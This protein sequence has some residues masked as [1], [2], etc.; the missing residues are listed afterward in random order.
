MVVSHGFLKQQAEVPLSEIELA[1]R[2]KEAFEE[3]P[4]AHSFEP[5]A[6]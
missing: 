3:D 2:R 5:E 4:L 6:G 1:L